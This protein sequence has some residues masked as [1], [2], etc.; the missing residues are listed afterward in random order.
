MSQK[1]TTIASVALIA[2]AMALAGCSSSSGGG[3]QTS[4]GISPATSKD[5]RVPDNAMR[6]KRSRLPIHYML[7]TGGTIYVRDTEA[8]R[9]IYHG[10]LSNNAVVTVDAAGV[11]VGDK[12]VA[13]AGKTPLGGDTLYELYVVK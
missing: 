4:G 5:V 11:K 1:F 12:Y 8:D 10:R 7:P 13:P 3:E 2:S 6:V 9:V